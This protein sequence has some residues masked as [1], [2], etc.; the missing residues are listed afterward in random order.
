MECVCVDSGSFVWG[1][2][3][4]VRCGPWFAPSSLNFDF[5]AFISWSKPASTASASFTSCFSRSTSDSVIVGPPNP[6]GGAPPNPGGPPKPRGSSKPADGPRP[7]DV[8]ETPPVK[9]S[10]RS[11][12]D[13]ES[14]RRVRAVGSMVAARARPVSRTTLSLPARYMVPPASCLK[15]CP[16]PGGWIGSR[17]TSR[18]CITG[19]TTRRVRAGLTL[20][21]GALRAGLKAMHVSMIEEGTLS[22]LLKG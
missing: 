20:M 16:Q 5:S 1:S 6:E 7:A 11:V 10:V 8:G 22:T 2:G 15:S 18:H 14:A 21:P 3:V 13:L 19:D 12:P 4:F 9:R 17:A